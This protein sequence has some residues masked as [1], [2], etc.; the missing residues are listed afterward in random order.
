MS[1]TALK[2]AVCKIVV[3]CKSH[4]KSKAFFGF[5]IQKETMDPSTQTMK[6]Q[7]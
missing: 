5:P 4:C 3:L 2:E 6:A 1:I 7:L